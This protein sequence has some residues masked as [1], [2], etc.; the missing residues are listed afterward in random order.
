[1]GNILVGG[2]LVVVG[3]ILGSALSNNAKKDL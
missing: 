1:M 3:V 2:L